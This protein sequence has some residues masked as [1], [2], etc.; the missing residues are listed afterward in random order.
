MNNIIHKVGLVLVPDYGTKILSIADRMH[1]W[2][3]QSDVNMIAIKQWYKLNRGKN[4]SFAFFQKGASNFVYNS[5]QSPSE[6]GASIIATIDDHHGPDWSEE[7]GD[8]PEWT[9][10]EVHGC[11]PDALIKSSLEEYGITNFEITDFGFI[12]R[13]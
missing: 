6:I 10:I 7:F 3:V 4:K 9:Y 2:V 12:G 13:E 5:E 8:I 1:V 11:K